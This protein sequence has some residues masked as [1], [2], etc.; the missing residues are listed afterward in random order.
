[1]ETEPL[2][3]IPEAFEG[4]S[5]PFLLKE[6]PQACLHT[7]GWGLLLTTPSHC[8]VQ[9]ASTSP[10]HLLVMRP[11]RHW[12]PFLLLFQADTKLCSTS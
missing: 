9:V 7:E 10:L 11:Q 5:W 8:L 2:L 4:S 12:K 3:T 1:M 6:H